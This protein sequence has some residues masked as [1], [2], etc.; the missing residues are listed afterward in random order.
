MISVVLDENGD[1]LFAVGRLQVARALRPEKDREE[2]GHCVANQ[3]VGAVALETAGKKTR[4]KHLAQLPWSHLALSI[5][6]R[7]RHLCKR[8]ITVPDM[9]TRARFC[10]TYFVEQFGLESIDEK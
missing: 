3:H 6:I 2:T 10:N 9:R 4:R 8:F 7:I 1:G 5:S